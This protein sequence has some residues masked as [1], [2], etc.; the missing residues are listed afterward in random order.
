M[1]NERREL[2]RGTLRKMKEERHKVGYG[3]DLRL[4]VS[5]DMYTTMMSDGDA[6]MDFNLGLVPFQEKWQGVL[7]HVDRRLDAPDAPEF[8]FSRVWTARTQAIWETA[9][10]GTVRVFVLPTDEVK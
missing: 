4:V 9:R 10:S 7:T 6:R 2:V 3:D 5:N 8:E 1:D